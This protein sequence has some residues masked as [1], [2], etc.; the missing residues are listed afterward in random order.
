[1]A[2]IERAGVVD[3]S[4]PPTIK[5]LVSYFLHLSHA[6]L[7]LVLSFS[8]L[9]LFAGGDILLSRG[10]PS[11]A[12]GLVAA[13]SL[14]DGFPETWT[15]SCCGGGAAAWRALAIVPGKGPRR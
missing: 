4:N 13:S 11:N 14:A 8:S 15:H 9:L 5:N 7:T 1:M 10:V 12:W 3:H 2:S 6:R